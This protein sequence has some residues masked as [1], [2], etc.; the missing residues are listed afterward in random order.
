MLWVSAC[1][2]SVVKCV[3]C[4]ASLFSVSLRLLFLLWFF[5]FLS[6]SGSSCSGINLKEEMERCTRTTRRRTLRTQPDTIKHREHF[7]VFISTSFVWDFCIKQAQHNWLPCT[8]PADQIC[9]I[10]IF[11]F[12]KQKP[13]N[14]YFLF[15]RISC[16]G[17]NSR[18]QTH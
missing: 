15:S 8:S 10:S 5:F 16:A 4:V 11:A 7:I 14:L 12:D 17:K 13:S 18:S 9:K 3:P 1:L 6:L 2:S